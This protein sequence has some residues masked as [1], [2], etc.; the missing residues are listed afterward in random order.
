MNITAANPKSCISTQLWSLK[1]KL[2]QVDEMMTPE[3]QRIVQ[4]THPELVFW[5]LNDRVRVA[6]Q[7][8]KRGSFPTTFDP[9]E[10]W[11]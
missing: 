11:N 5:H 10:A 4:E 2:Q 8:N 6:K 1:K 9:S 3:R 7:K